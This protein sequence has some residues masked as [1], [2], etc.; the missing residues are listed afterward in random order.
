MQRI[1]ELEGVIDDRAVIGERAVVVAGFLGE[2]T[3]ILDGVAQSD[4]GVGVSIV[5]DPAGGGLD[6]I[7]SDQGGGIIAGGREADGGA[8]VVGIGEGDFGGN[9][10]CLQGFLFAVEVVQVGVDQPSSLS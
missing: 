9:Y 7:E 6:Q 10:T 1:D 3:A 5:E 2:E 8:S 4:W